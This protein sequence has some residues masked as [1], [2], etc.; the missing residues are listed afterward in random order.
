MGHFTEELYD[1]HLASFLKDRP[2]GP[3]GVFAYGSLIWKRV[4]EPTAELRATALDWHR[5]F[6][7]RQK[8]V[9]GT[10]ECPGLMMQIDRGG[11]C[12]GVL[13]MVPEGREWEILSDVWRREMTVRPPSY[14]PRWIDGKV[15]GEKGTRKALAFTANPESPNYAGQLPLDEVAACL[16]EAC[17]P[18]GTGAEYLLQTVTSLEREGFHDPYL[19]DLQERVAELI[20]DRHS[21][22]HGRA[23]QRSQCGASPSA[24]RRQSQCGGAGGRGWGRGGIGRVRPLR[25]G[26]QGVMPR[27]LRAQRNQ[28]AS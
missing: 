5:S 6:S 17:G 28:S 27:S 4:F 25:A 12:E 23:S 26:M 10:P 11:I 18:W 3:I 21:E 13:Q 1:E 20:E 16:S 22:A 15:Q 14:I 9:R 24:G 19:W 2:E 7:L 8:R